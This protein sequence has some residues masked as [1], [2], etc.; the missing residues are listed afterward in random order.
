MPVHE[1]IDSQTD[2]EDISGKMIKT[3]LPTQGNS[4][5]KLSC[6]LGNCSFLR[7]V[8]IANAMISNNVPHGRGHTIECGKGNGIDIA[9]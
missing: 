9:A 7:S 5:Y 2:K 6:L 3:S 4:W 8:K 1:T